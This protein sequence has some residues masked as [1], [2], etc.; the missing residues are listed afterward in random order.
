MSVDILIIHPDATKRKQLRE[1]VHQRGFESCE[2]D[3]AVEGVLLAREASPRGVI[4]DMSP[5][6]M[7]G[8]VALKLIRTQ[9]KEDAKVFS[10][11][12]EDPGLQSLA[13]ELGADGASN[14]A[15]N[16]VATFLTSITPSRRRSNFISSLP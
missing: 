8:F 14:E 13:I 15:A 7:D 11:G 4:M 10:L 9:L 16:H 6:G 1:I 5:N 3:S 2:T 12:V